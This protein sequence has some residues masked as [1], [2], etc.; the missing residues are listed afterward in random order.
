MVKPLKKEKS[1]LEIS[2]KKN[3]VK[4]NDDDISV[5]LD[6][7]IVNIDNQ[8]DKELQE[9]IDEDDELVIVE[10]NVD[11]DINIDDTDND[12]KD[13]YSHINFIHSELDTQPNTWGNPGKNCTNIQKINYS[14]QIRN[15]SQEEQNDI[16]LVLID[17][18][19]RC[20]CCMKCYDIIKD[21]CFIAFGHFFT[22]PHYHV[23][24]NFFDIV[25]KTK[26]NGMVILKKKKKKNIPKKFIK[27]F[28]LIKI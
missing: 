12:N 19:F 16:D 11:L 14:N 22:R 8:K 26:D 13:K 21:D 28:K 27:K 17:G 20:A 7:E 3:D 4:N 15:L 5:L 23:V 2:S 1:D 6:E 9:V 18:R 24:L 10:E 25:E